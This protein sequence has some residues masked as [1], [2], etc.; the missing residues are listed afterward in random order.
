MDT[1]ELRPAWKRAVDIVGG[2]CALAV[3]AIPMIAIAS[4][5]MAESGRPVLL[6]QRRIGVHGDEF[7]MWKFRTLPAN[8]PQMAKSELRA[9]GLDPSPLGRF[10]RRYSLDELPQLLNI[11]AGDMSLIGPRPALFTQTDLT[12]MRRQAGVLRVRPG[13]TGLAQIHGRENLTLEEKVALDA[14]YV[15]RLSPLLDL[16]IVLRTA[17]AVLG[18][19]GSY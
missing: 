9:S 7:A 16:S 19:R 5:I 18:A 17:S 2:L 14:E 6:K 12:A 1:S 8:T 11:V 4:A 15:Q 10:L 13:L 3:A